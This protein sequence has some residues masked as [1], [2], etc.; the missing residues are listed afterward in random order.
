MIFSEKPVPT[1]PDH[2]LIAPHIFGTAFVAMLRMIPP[3]RA[4][5]RR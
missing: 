2:A 4:V 3:L 1:F 5:Q